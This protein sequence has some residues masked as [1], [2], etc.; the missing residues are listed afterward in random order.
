[1][2]TLSTHTHIQTRTNR[3]DRFAASFC[4]CCYI[5]YIQT[6]LPTYLP[7]LPY[8]PYPTYLPFGPLL[9]LLLLLPHEARQ[10]LFLLPL[11]PLLVPLR[12]DLLALDL[13]R[14]GRGEVLVM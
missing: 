8:Q 3:L 1:M 13:L 5:P 11:G 12:Q 9:R 6:Q 10:L 14:E 4:C 2:P 7:T